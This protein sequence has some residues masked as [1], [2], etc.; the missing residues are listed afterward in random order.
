M[1]ELLLCE[2]FGGPDIDAGLRW[3]CPPA[4]WSVD[5]DRSVLVVEPDAESDF[6]QKPHTNH[7][8]D[9]GHFLFMPVRGDYVMT[10]R[11][12]FHPACQY[13]QAGLMVR[14]STTCWLKTSVEYEPDEPSLL[15]AVVTNGGFSDWSTQPFPAG[16][17]EIRIRI[18]REG[19]DHIVQSSF[20]GENWTQI[21]AARLH[22]DTGGAVECG[23][24]ACSPTGAGFRAEF[25][26]L[27]IE[28]E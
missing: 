27:K 18:R 20:D 22:D 5:A 4:K 11:V 17:D 25:A 9:N 21:R 7:R 13:D 24:Y 14:L 2:E 12:R 1:S 28:T 3:F 8:A 19:V 16:R 15:G 26:F 10:T 6:W 23:L